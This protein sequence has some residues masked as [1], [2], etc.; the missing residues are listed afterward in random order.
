MPRCTL[1]VVPSYHPTLTLF[2]G[3]PGSGK[4]TVAKRI[5]TDTGAIRICTDDW[6]QLLGVSHSDEEFHGRL[7]MTSYEHALRLLAAGVDVILED[8][9][10]TKPERKEK[11]ADA[12]KLDVRT[13]LH[14][15]DPTLEELRKRIEHR[16]A[17][18]PPGAVPVKTEDLTM[19]HQT[20]F[21]RPSTR[22]LARFDEVTLHR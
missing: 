9:L 12:N 15:L 14:Y 1:N 18:L 5:E 13:H 6:Q 16:N 3:L 7:Q 22:E 20:V 4:T 19:W 11:L 8:G 17:A 21:E 10:W 2:C